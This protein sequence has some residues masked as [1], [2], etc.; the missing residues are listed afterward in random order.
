MKDLAIFMKK[1][2]RNFMKGTSNKV[3][4][5]VKVD[6]TFSKVLIR[7]ISMKDYSRMIYIMEK[8]SIDG[9]METLIEETSI[10]VNKMVLVI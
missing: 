3:K 8:V 1:L 7:V 5:V 6:L 10:K 9:Q 4:R 2:K